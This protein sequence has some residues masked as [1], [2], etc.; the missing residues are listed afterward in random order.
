MGGPIDIKQKGCELVIHD[1]NHDRLVIKLRCKAV[2][3]SDQGGLRCK[4]A[5]DLS[6][7]RDVCSMLFKIWKK[8]EYWNKTNEIDMFE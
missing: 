7:M 4:H 2:L 8:M 3:D 6:N 1:Y 5:I